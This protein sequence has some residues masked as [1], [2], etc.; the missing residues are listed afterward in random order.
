M[1]LMLENW[2]RYLKEN[3]EDYD[4]EFEHEEPWE[5]GG[6]PRTPVQKIVSMVEGNDKNNIMQARNLVQSGEVGIEDVI[7][8]LLTR[9]TA[10]IIEELTLVT[11]HDYAKPRPDDYYDRLN[12][13][14]RDMYR[15]RGGIGKFIAGSSPYENQVERLIEDAVPE[16]DYFD[17]LRDYQA[18]QAQEESIK[19]LEDS[20]KSLLSYWDESIKFGTG[21]GAK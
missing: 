11:T 16:P 19:K 7:N 1:K 13:L 5:K 4:D 10:I 20:K 17:K 3:D 6:P 15:L 9:Y 18:Q 21:R 8:E 14:E 12:E 2:R